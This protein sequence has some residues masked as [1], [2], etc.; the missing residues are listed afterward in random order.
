M[1]TIS[2]WAGAGDVVAQQIKQRVMDQLTQAK[3][4]EEKRQN[5]ANENLRRQQIDSANEIKR[6]A[7]L[8]RQQNAKDIAA[9]RDENTFFRGLTLRPANTVV[10][11]DE[12]P[13][14]NKYGV[15][16]MLQTRPLDVSQAMPAA[17]VPS[18]ESSAD[19]PAVLRG[20][21]VAAQP[22]AQ[23]SSLPGVPGQ[24]LFTGTAGNQLSQERID[25]QSEIAA[26]RSEAAQARQAALDAY[27]EA[28]LGLRERDVSRRE[29]TFDNRTNPPD[30]PRLPVGVQDYLT[31][32]RATYGDDLSS[33]EQEFSKALPDIRAAHPRL[34]SARAVSTLRSMFGAAPGASKTL[35]TLNGLGV[36][37]GNGT[38]APLRI[39]GNIVGASPQPD[40]GRGAAAATGGPAPSTM[41][42]TELRGV[43]QRLGI[44][45]A[46]AEQQATSRGFTV[47][48]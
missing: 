12:E 8:D 44:S 3:F 24:R 37:G 5:L 30:D 18:L 2:D 43:A 26:A 45:E 38:G 35:Q 4:E 1:A 31:R 29:G 13:Q 28:N 27:R 23:N 6:Q 9:T 21:L 47:V 34:D 25:N 16:G 11:P 39:R 22:P 17:S 19:K 41:T 40:G 33:A 36:L 7:E 20:R 48:P 32:L 10:S 46:Q 42:R 15:S 14:F